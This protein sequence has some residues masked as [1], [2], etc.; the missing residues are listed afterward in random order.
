MRK[1]ID[2]FNSW[3]YGMNIWIDYNDNGLFNETRT[4][5]DKGKF[6]VPT[7]RNLS[8]TAPYFHD[9]S[10]ETLDE[11]LQVF[12]AGGRVIT[13]GINAGDGRKNIY[14][15]KNITGYTLTNTER[16]DLINF[17]LSLDDSTILV[18]PQFNNPFV[19]KKN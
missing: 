18:N 14:K 2:F 6:R 12:E 17:L 8:F 16:M 15:D 4:E 11:A 3:S 1:S 19:N 10:A 13:K 5:T 7:L 9:G